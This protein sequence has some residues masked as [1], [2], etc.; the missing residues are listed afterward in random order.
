MGVTIHFEGKLSSP[1]NFQRVISIAISHAE[2]YNLPYVHIQEERK[3]LER[4]RDEKSWDYEGPVK[5]IQLQPH[6]NT[7]PF[8]LEFDENFYLQDYCK[9]Q[10]APV[11]VHI[12]L[13]EL[14]KRIEPFFET[15]E[16]KDEGEYWESGDVDLLQRNIDDCFDLI[17]RAKQVNDKLEGPF[18]LESGRI[19]DLM[20]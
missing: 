16:I 5:G 15:F 18:R 7:D 13:I 20:G 10:F 12:C 3:L 6:Y 11:N 14:L 9:T 2:E 8:I 1:D 19:V 17:E 4:V